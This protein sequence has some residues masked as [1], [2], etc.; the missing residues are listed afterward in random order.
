LLFANVGVTFVPEE[1]PPVE[2][3]EEE[4]AMEFWEETLAA[5]EEEE[6]HERF[7]Q[8]CSLNE[9]F[10][11]AAHCYSLE[12]NKRGKDPIAERQLE[13]I[14]YLV[15]QQL[16]A[17]QTDKKDFSAQKRR[18]NTILLLFLFVFLVLL[19]YLLFQRWGAQSPSNLLN[20]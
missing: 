12:K 3:P 20:F 6:R 2:L 5:W 10:D 15:Q 16:L 13:R 9:L 1:R 17:E 14:V 19:L 4:T 18:W 11:F 7:L 8:Y